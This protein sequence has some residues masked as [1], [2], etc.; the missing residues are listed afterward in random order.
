MIAP[1]GGTFGLSVER[2]GD[3]LHD[4]RAV[5]LEICAQLSGQRIDGLIDDNLLSVAAPS[6]SAAWKHRETHS[7]SE[8]STEALLQCDS[9]TYVPFK[10]L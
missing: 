8:A 3:M 5:V 9:R 2:I 7:D 1:Q 4:E 10:T 6:A